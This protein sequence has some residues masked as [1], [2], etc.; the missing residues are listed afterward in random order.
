MCKLIFALLGIFLFLQPSTAQTPILFMEGEVSTAINER[1]MAISPDGN[2]MYYTLQ[3]NRNILSTIIHRTRTPNGWSRPEVAAFSGVFNDL[4]P[5]FSPDGQRLFFCSNRPLSGDQTKDYDIWVMHKT[6]TGWSEPKNLGAPVN[7]AGN[8]FYPSLANNGNLYFTAEKEDG[9]G[10]EDIFIARFEGEKYVAPIPLDTAINSKLWEFNAFVAPDESFILFTSYG[11]KDD[12]GGGDLYMSV[13]LNGH[14][15][16]ARNLTAINSPVLDYCPF[17][18]KGTLYI[19]SG[20]HHV[21]SSRQ[22]HTDYNALMKWYNGAANGSENIF[23]VDFAALV[24]I[25]N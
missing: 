14:W 7:T 5:A 21:Q 10:R 6:A 11:R 18:H 17:V 3:S 2:E 20:R 22:K 19:T 24:K 1:D 4:E 12:A 13:R 25:M 9:I 8:E 23:T 16:P 15:Q